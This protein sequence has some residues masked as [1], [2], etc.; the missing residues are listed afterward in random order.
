MVIFL[1]IMAI[2]C[3]IVVAFC[4]ISLFVFVKSTDQN[5]RKNIFP[6]TVFGLVFGVLCWLFCHIIHYEIVDRP[7]KEQAKLEQEIKWQ[8]LGCP[9]YQ[10]QCEGKHKYAC[11][12]K[13]AIVGRNRID[14]SDSG[15]IFVQ[16]FPSHKFSSINRFI[17][18]SGP[19]FE[20]NA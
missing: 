14:G 10:S 7:K 18:I 17:T 16:C 9:V 4:L 15:D 13:A 12:K 20:P 8:K 1:S 5:C 3:F 2:A 11:E 19:D 6:A